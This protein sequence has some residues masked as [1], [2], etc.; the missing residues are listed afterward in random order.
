MSPTTTQVIQLLIAGV[1]TG[2]IYA[3]VAVGFNIIFK[4]TDAI[5]FAQGE[6]VMMGGMLAATATRRGTCRSG[7]HASARSSSSASWVSSRSA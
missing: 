1:T 5:N 6:W 7:S 4:S 3:I 2:S